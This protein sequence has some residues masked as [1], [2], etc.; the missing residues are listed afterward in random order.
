[1]IGEFYAAQARREAANDAGDLQGGQAAAHDMAA[2]IATYESATPIVSVSRCPF[3]G[4]VFETSLDI[5]GLDGMWWVYDRD[6]RPYVATP[7]TLLAWTGSMQLDGPVPNLPLKSMVGPTAPFV[8]PR[9]LEHPSITAVMS[10]IL[11]GEHV[12]FP[13]VYYAQPVPPDVERIDDWGHDV[14][15]YTRSDGS[16]SSARTTEDDTA[17]DTDIT[18]WIKR[19]KLAWIAPGDID[20]ELRT[21]AT[22]C[23]FTTVGG[24]RNR[25]YIQYGKVWTAND[26]DFRQGT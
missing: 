10:S 21:S 5:F 18:Q 23:P 4:E 15:Y 25:Q 16:P 9:L 11:I 6:Y 22:D 8:Y 13:V 17:K 20:L 12:G 7:P 26:R 1:M 2:V 24:D 3:T 19:G 14:Y